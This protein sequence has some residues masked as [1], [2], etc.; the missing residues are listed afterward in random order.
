MK[1]T[2]TPTPHYKIKEAGA[3]KDLALNEYYFVCDNAGHYLKSKFKAEFDEVCSWENI[4]FYD[5]IKTNQ[6]LHFKIAST[7]RKRGFSKMQTSA[8]IEIGVFDFHLIQ[9]DLTSHITKIEIGGK[10]KAET[11]EML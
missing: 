5:K 10:Q 2:N 3:D 4:L 6:F 9:S 1:L 7:W 11:Y 8:K